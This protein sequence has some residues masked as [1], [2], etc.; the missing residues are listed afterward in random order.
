MIGIAPV[1][2]RRTSRQRTF[3]CAK[4]AIV[5]SLPA[6]F[7]LTACD[8]S[9]TAFEEN[10]LVF[11]MYGYLD[12]SR[13]TQWLRVT[14]IRI[15]VETA[16][17]PVDAV[18]TIEEVE[19]GR[20]IVM[21]DSLFS[22]RPLDPSGA[23]IY[24]H[25][26][27]TSE[28]IREGFSYRVA[29]TRSDGAISTATVLVPEEEEEIWVIVRKRQNIPIP[30]GRSLDRLRVFGVNHFA[31]VE[32]VQDVPSHCEYPLPEWREWQQ[33]L[34]SETSGE[35][36]DYFQIGWSVT[37]RPSFVGL[38]P[39]CPP[40]TYNPR[41]PGMQRVAVIVTESPWPY[42]PSLDRRVT[43]HPNT[44]SNVTNGV[45]FVAGVLIR[46]FPYEPE[47][48]TLSILGDFCDITF[49][50]ES[51]TLE[52]R[53]W[54]SCENEPLAGTAVSLREVSGNRIRPT[55]TDAAGNFRIRGLDPGMTY[56]MSVTRPRF[57]PYETDLVLNPAESRTL[58]PIDLEW[59]FVFDPCQFQ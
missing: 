30:A 17:G 3:G 38:P 1:W 24:A 45:G 14:P 33:R 29:A 8:E 16:P 42:D 32:T 56:R 43:S 11:S 13:E 26:F 23:D 19:T 47:L 53:I 27:S 59:E 22:Y 21:S 39:P 44:A 57:L 31:M 4:A 58:P 52:G 48:C 50:R 34:Q 15:S 9:F 7:L 49:N 55:T 12:P 10:D 41:G 18:V 2:M 35:E 51:A 20:I 28:P 5:L 37:M 54:D 40:E 6:L 25:N 36:D 46:E